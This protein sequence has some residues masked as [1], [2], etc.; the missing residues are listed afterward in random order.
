MNIRTN[1]QTNKQ[2]SNKLTYLPTY[3]TSIYLITQMNEQIYKSIQPELM[4]KWT[5]KQ[6][7]NLLSI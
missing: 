4:N 5:N 7:T 1:K 6:L 2:K 3:Q